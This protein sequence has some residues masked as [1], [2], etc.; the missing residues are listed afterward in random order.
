[1]NVILAVEDC[2]TLRRGDLLG[3]WQNVNIS[4]WHASHEK[5][6]KQD[7]LKPMP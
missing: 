2:T 1:M 7:L 3:W 6:L 4:Q 5:P